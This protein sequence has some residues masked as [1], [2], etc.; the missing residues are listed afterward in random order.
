MDSSYFSVADP[1]SSLALS[2]DTASD[3]GA[4]RIAD[5]RVIARLHVSVAPL[6]NGQQAATEDDGHDEQEKRWNPD[7]RSHT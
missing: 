2:A 5:G 6:G 4:S 7:W 1:L 3:V